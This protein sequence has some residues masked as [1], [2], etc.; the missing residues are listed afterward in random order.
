MKKII[1]IDKDAEKY[2]NNMEL[3]LMKDKKDLDQLIASLRIESR[4]K[5]EERKQQILQ[6][7]IKAATIDAEQIVTGKESEIKRLM[8]MYE[9]SKNDIVQEIIHEIVISN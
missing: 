5:V 6:E 4:N 1:S 3:K 8:N 9:K 7:K 2:R